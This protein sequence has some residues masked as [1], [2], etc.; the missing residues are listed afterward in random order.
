MFVEVE[1]YPKSVE[2]QGHPGYEGQRLASKIAADGLTILINSTGVGN[3]SCWRRNP[4]IYSSHTFLNAYPGYC[5]Q[6][7]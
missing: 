3:A 4:P 5:Q 7:L 2:Q 1:P 6:G